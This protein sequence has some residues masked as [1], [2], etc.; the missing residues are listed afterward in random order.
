MHNINKLIFVSC[1][2]GT[3]YW[4]KCA[5]HRCFRFSNNIQPLFLPKVTISCQVRMLVHTSR[6]GNQRLTKRLCREWIS[7]KGF[8]FKAI[9]RHSLNNHDISKHV[10]YDKVVSILLS[11]CPTYYVQNGSAWWSDKHIYFHVL[12]FFRFWTYIPYSRCL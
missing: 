11:R 7:N 5:S 9:D 10:L 3:Y 4:N 12:V 2:W 1:L 6:Y 8:Q